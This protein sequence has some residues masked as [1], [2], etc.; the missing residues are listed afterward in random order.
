MDEQGRGKVIRWNESIPSTGER[1]PDLVAFLD[2]VLR[3]PIKWEYHHRWL[4]PMLEVAVRIYPHRDVQDIYLSLRISGFDTESL[5]R[6]A[7]SQL[8]LV[9][10]AVRSFKFDEPKRTK[11]EDD[12]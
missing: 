4:G 11:I 10:E 3:P 9:D 7:L 8:K 1:L 2:S 6:D 5:K 12:E